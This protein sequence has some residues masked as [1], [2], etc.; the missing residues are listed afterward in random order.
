LGG[1]SR[2]SE[3]GEVKEFLKIERRWLGG[4]TIYFLFIVELNLKLLN[5][6]KLFSWT[7]KFMV[8]LQIHV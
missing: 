6:D 7:S 4:V 8:P 3:K 1:T 5:S 2:V